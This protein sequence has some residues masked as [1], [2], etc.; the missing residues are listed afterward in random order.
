[1]IKPLTFVY[2]VIIIIVNIMYCAVFISYYTSCIVV[3]NINL[4]VYISSYIRVYTVIE[5][6]IRDYYCKTHVQPFIII[7][8]YFT[9]EILNGLEC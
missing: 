9:Q 1:M 3:G 8:Y 2:S 7:N 5:C 4:E 6:I